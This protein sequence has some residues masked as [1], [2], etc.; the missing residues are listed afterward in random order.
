[1]EKNSN[2]IKTHNSLILRGGSRRGRVMQVL[3]IFNQQQKYHFIVNEIMGGA[4]NN[5]GNT[6]SSF[7]VPSVG[8]FAEGGRGPRPYTKRAK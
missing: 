8:K 4:N 5:I 3:G 1:M 2:K 6:N 7:P